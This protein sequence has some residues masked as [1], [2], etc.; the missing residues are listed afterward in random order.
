M[1]FYAIQVDQENRI[2]NFF[3][4]D[5]RSKINYNSFRDVLCFDTTYRT[6]KYNMICVPFVGVNH[7]CETSYVI[8]FSL[9]KKKSLLIMEFP[10]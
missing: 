7:H 5:G 1:F 3:W 2:I 4:R 8:N 10:V 6:N 9:K